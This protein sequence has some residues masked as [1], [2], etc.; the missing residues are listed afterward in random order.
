MIETIRQDD[1]EDGSECMSRADGRWHGHGD[2][3]RRRRGADG[4]GRWPSR[5]ADRL[6]AGPFRANGDRR[7]QARCLPRTTPG[8]ARHPHQLRRHRLLGRRHHHRPGR[9]RR[10][11]VPPAREP[12]D[13]EGQDLDDGPGTKVGQGES[14][15]V[16]TKD[17]LVRLQAPRFFV[18]KDEVVLSANVHNK[19][20]TK[21]AVQVVLEFD[22][23]VLQPMSETAM[24]QTVEIAAGSEHRVDWRVKVAHEGQ[25]VIR[26]K[27]LTDEESDA[28]Q[29]TFPAYVHGMLKTEAFAGAIRPDQEKAQVVLRVPAERKPDQSRLEVRYSPDPGR[30]AGRRPALPRRLSLRLH[31]ADPEPLPA[32][33]HHPEGADQP[34][35]RPEGD[36]GQAHQPQ[37]PADRRRPRA[38]A[39]NGRATSTTRSSTRPRSPRWPRA[40]IQRLADMQLSDGGW[41]WFSGYG[42]FSSPHTTALVVHGLQVARQNDLSLPEGMLERGVAWLTDYQAKQVRAARERQSARS[43]RTRRPPTTSTRWSSWS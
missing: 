15:I 8:P 19:L 42:E 16:T 21:K 24:A 37:R 36:P 39:S 2:G 38:G 6:E 13:L 26:M 11:R 41:G 33:G 1:A 28:A 7:R 40:G 4:H 23:S 12:D 43:S 3:S 9:H 25:A 18:E 20:K 14:E 17:L 32:D 29:M 34:R 31:R 22:G 5:M 30:R 35:A 10:G 27:A